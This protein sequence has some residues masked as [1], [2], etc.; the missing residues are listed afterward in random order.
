[1]SR[2]M[3]IRWEKRRKYIKKNNEPDVAGGCLR[4]I[5]KFYWSLPVLIV[6]IRGE[7]KT[8][9][10]LADRKTKRKQFPLTKKSSDAISIFDKPKF[11]TPDE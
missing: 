10:T 2:G 11:E 6:T 3:Q 1:M 5:Y 9:Y 7:N 8:N 4:V